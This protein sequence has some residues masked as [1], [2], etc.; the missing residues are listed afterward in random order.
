MSVADGVD[1][2]VDVAGDDEVA[3]PAEMTLDRARENGKVHPR[4]ADG[5]IVAHR[6]LWG[7]RSSGHVSSD[8]ATR[9]RCDGVR[10]A[11]TAPCRA[12]SAAAR[13]SVRW[14][15]WKVMMEFILD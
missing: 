4:A 15:A 1:G 11:G 2:R 5:R 13:R 8:Q 3:R 9:S 7:T 14:C 6:R 10:V 12:Y